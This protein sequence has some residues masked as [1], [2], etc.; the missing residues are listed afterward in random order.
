MLALAKVQVC[1]II[2]KFTLNSLKQYSL[3]LI[4]S[5]SVKSCHCWLWLHLSEWYKS[6]HLSLKEANCISV[7]HSWYFWLTEYFLRLQNTIKTAGK[8]SKV[9]KMWKCSTTAAFCDISA[10]FK[11]LVNIEYIIC[12]SCKIYTIIQ[13]TGLSYVTTP[14]TSQ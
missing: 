11:A 10:R 3:P 14:S 5:G 8:T 4:Q 1:R 12:T 13:A 2:F 6:C 9:L 7:P